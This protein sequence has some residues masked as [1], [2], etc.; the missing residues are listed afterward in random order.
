MGVSNLLQ[1][2]RPMQ[3]CVAIKNYAGSIVAVDAMCWIHRGMISSA[4]ANVTGD[5]CDKYI[6]FIISML[7]VLL[8][9]KITPIM[10]F[11]GYEMPSKERENQSRR[12]RRDKARAEALAMIK[13]NRGSINTEIMRKC[14]QAITITPEVIARVMEICREMNIRVLVAPYEADAQVAYLCRSGIAHC[15]ISEDS[16]LLAYGCPRV[17]Y[18]LE[19]D[20]RADEVRLDFSSDPDVK[21][22]KGMLKGLSHRMFVAMCV[23]SGS[24]YDDG[25]HIYGMGIKLAH[26]FILQYDNIPSVMTALEETASWTKKLPTHVTVKQLEEH[27]LNVS[28]IFLHN[29]VYD[30]RS[31]TLVHINPIVKGESHMDIIVDLC[32]RLRQ[33][34][35][36][37]TVSEGRVNPR[38]GEPLSYYV[39]ENDKELTEGMHFP[40]VNVFYTAVKPGESDSTKD[41][42]L[43]EVESASPDAQPEQQVTD[44]SLD[45]SNAVS[46]PVREPVLELSQLRAPTISPDGGEK[47]VDR[48]NTDESNASL[49]TCDEFEPPTRSQKRKIRA[50]INDSERVI[51]TRSK[52]SC[53]QPMSL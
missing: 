5:P 4:V 18:K 14:M 11:D 50:L 32:Y 47:I 27:Y 3:K 13:K 38:N 16:D 41:A 22:T 37:R 1:F 31:D 24:D 48:L 29:V 46:C 35:N 42:L 10:V 28:Q 17:W 30:I 40:D 25:C 12:D 44:S 21:C 52:R 9:H 15:A 7:S 45:D 36:F 23:L 20:G 43:E 33:K 8:S 26:R 49:S 51:I 53:F 34:T 19:R 6:K 39:T 2:L